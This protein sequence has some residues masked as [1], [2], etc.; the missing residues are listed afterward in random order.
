MACVCVYVWSNYENLQNSGLAKPW[1]TIFS[2]VENIWG[3]AQGG[4]L[5]KYT[6]YSQAELMFVGKTWLFLM[7]LDFTLT[8]K[9]PFVWKKVE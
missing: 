9:A 2:S 3:I 6:D 7:V 1:P 4:V 5:E 8:E